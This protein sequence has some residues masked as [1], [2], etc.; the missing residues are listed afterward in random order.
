MERQIVFLNQKLEQNE[1]MVAD[2][3]RD[4]E[5]TF[6]EYEYMKKVTEGIEYSNEDLQRNLIN[7]QNEIGILSD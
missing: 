5:N 4:K 1:Q 6:K 3:S 2:L 7:A